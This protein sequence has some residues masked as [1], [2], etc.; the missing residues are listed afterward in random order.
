M[1]AFLSHCLIAMVLGTSLSSAAAT[2]DDSAEER[3][4]NHE[5]GGPQ[6]FVYTVT[7]PAGDNAVAAFVRDR[8]TGRIRSMGRYATGGQG[9]PRTGAVSQHAI[10]SQGN[11]LYAVNPGSNDISA[12]AILADGSLRLL[13]VVP[14]GGRA[15]VS[16]ALH[17]DLLYV[18]NFGTFDAENAPA[19]YSGFR[20]QRD[21]SPVPIPGSTIVLERGDALSDIVFNPHGCLL[22]GTRTGGSIIDSFWV[23][24]S[25]RLVR[26]DLLRN[27]PGAFGAAFHP[28][29]SWQ[30]FANY[31][32]PVSGTAGAVASFRVDG[33]GR[34]EGTGVLTDPSLQAPCWLVLTPNGRLLWVSSAFS[35]ALTLY[36]V[37]NDGR[38]T[39]GSAL[40][41]ADGPASLD[42]ALD[43]DGRYLYQLRAVN[44]DTPGQPIAPHIRVL[45]VTGQSSDAGL[46]LVQD[47]TLDEDLATSGITGLTVV[48][49]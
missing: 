36:S 47:L 46:A 23:T 4:G 13:A 25:G 3:Q 30:L 28:L 44:L 22:I 37:S 49:R 45:R 34:L 48:D 32:A 1:K 14:S 42:I 29:R 21:G 12:F 43:R 20:L 27:Q 24:P 15:P 16:L 11:H 5:W 39:Q 35:R 7:N 33:R 26:A 9:D 40:V 38:L 18:A 31:V 41:P 6:S 8:R 2:E 17:G 10:V 19:S